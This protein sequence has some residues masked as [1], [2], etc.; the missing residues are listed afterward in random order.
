MQNVIYIFF[1]LKGRGTYA[2]MVL[3]IC[4]FFW[5]Y[6]GNLNKNSRCSLFQSSD[7]DSKIQF[8]NQNTTMTAFIHTFDYGITVIF[9]NSNSNKVIQ[10]LV[11]PRPLQWAS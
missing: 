2:M 8:L 10:N 5:Q 9:E 3:G 11:R 6:F 7:G 4:P 1:D